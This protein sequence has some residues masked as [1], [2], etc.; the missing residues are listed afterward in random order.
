MVDFKL[1]K[2]LAS[3]AAGLLVS[4]AQAADPME[5]LPVQS[6][7][8]ACNKAALGS[9]A[10]WEQCSSAIT[11]A[12]D[13]YRR[14]VEKAAGAVKPAQM[15]PGDYT[16]LQ[17]AL[18]KMKADAGRPVNS[19]DNSDAGHYQQV[20]FKATQAIGNANAAARFLPGDDKSLIQ[21]GE[22]LEATARASRSDLIQSLKR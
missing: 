3:A 14:A 6:I 7:K 10:Q 18:A 12:A 13:S 1:S 9:P 2:L 20:T 15:N 22:H 19:P 16:S 4:T 8:A 21:G 17:G 5:S 11:G